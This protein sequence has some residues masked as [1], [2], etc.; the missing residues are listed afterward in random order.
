MKFVKYVLLKEYVDWRQHGYVTPIKNELQCGACWAF[1]ATGALEGQEAKKHS[2]VSLSEQNLVDC[3]Q[4]YGNFGCNGGWMVSAYRYVIDKGLDT[5][6]S[7]QYKG[8]QEKCHFNPRTIGVKA[9][10]S[11][12][13]IT[14]K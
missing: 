8:V 7:Y 12:F 9:T 2:L 6:A 5:E 13:H 4:A 11:Y 14:I 1:S 3:S 10:V